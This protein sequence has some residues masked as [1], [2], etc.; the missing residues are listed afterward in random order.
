MDEHTVGKLT[1][2]TLRFLFN[3]PILKNKFLAC[4]SPEDIKRLIWDKYKDTFIDEKEKN[5]FLKGI[6]LN[7]FDALYWW[8]TEY[9]NSQHLPTTK[10]AQ[11]GVCLPPNYGN[12]GNPT[13]IQKTI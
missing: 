13:E 9:K 7:N 12:G 11:G 6:K 4:N 10:K 1:Y 3:H 2:E 5:A 8:I